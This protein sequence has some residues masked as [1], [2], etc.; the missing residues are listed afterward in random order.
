MT[1][2]FEKLYARLGARYPVLL[3]VLAGTSIPLLTLLAAGIL[4]LYV[5]TTT[6]GDFGKLLLVVVPWMG[7]VAVGAELSVARI[8]YS[9]L[10]TWIRQDSDR[11]EQAWRAAVVDLP[12]AVLTLSL[13]H[14]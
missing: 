12:R 9:S 13:I 4:P 14:I 1:I 11:P 7:L 2:S 10:V 8:V 6:V 3:L 5:K